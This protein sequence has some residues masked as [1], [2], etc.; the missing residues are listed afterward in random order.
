MGNKGNYEM[1]EKK[2]LPG[3]PPTPPGKFK[4]NKEAT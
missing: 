4:N 3:P 2:V 1:F